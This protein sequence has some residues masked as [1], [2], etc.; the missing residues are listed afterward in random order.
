M[1]GLIRYNVANSHYSR[2]VSFNSDEVSLSS[3]VFGIE[4][5]VKRAATKIRVN[6]FNREK[7]VWRYRF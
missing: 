1:H 7:L 5:R 6:T 4:I 2:L 3:F